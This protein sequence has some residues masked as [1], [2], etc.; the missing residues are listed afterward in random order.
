MSLILHVIIKAG[1]EIKLKVVLSEYVSQ[2]I[3]DKFG[4]RSLRG[5]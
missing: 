2:T 3:L 4:S 1:S 5:N